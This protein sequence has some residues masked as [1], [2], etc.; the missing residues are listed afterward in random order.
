LKDVLKIKWA[1]SL[2]SIVGLTVERSSSGFELHQPVLI[3]SILEENWTSGVMA[4]TPLPPGFNA[5]T[6]ESGIKEDSCRY[7]HVIGCLSYLA[8][9]THPD[10]CFAVNFLAHFAAKPGPEH[11][12]GL[13]NLV[14]YLAGRKHQRLRLFPQRDNT[15]LKSFADASWGGEF[16]RSTYGVFISFLN[17]PI[18]WISRRQLSPAASTCHA[19]YMALGTET[20]QTLWVCHLLRC[21]NCFWDG[22][23]VL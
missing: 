21:G 20:R 16:A 15:P 22:L 11:W 3:D 9:R 12:K 10:I 7:L 2:T 5:L 14:N 4:S 19:E 1:D 17:C 23:A 13:R 6:D 18:L 8:V